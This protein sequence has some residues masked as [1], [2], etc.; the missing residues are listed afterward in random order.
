MTVDSAH[1]TAAETLAAIAE[2][3]LSAQAHARDCLD[4]IAERDPAVRAWAFLDPARVMAAAEA[5]DR[6][7][8]KGRLHGLAIG[9]K[10]VILTADMP[11][12]YNAPRHRGDNARIDAACVALLRDAGALMLGKTHTVEYAATG[13][14][15][16]TRNP[17]DHRRTPGGSSS[18]SAA[19]VADFHVSV[20]LGTQT[21]GSIIRPAAYCGVFGFKPT[22]GLVSREGAKAFAPT[23]DTVGWLARS[24]SDLTLIYDVFDTEGGDGPDL[25][26]RDMRI[27]VCRSPVWGQAQDATRR[28]LATGVR[29]LRRDGARIEDL[30]LPDS[31]AHLVGDHGLIMAAEGR[32]SFL[33]NYR[34]C[35]SRLHPSLRAMVENVAG[36]TGR[37]L[38]KAYD[39]AAA[40]RANFDRI[41]SGFDAILTPSVVGE[42]PIG[43]KATGPLTFNA[44][45]SLLHVPTINVPGLVGLKGLP[46]GLTVVGPRFADRQ[47]LAAARVIGD[48]FAR[49][50]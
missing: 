38:A 30:D 8:A 39:R 41:A 11:T 2:G 4:R 3:S 47:V 26:L 46:V 1:L 25:D 34:D 5:L 45:W 42:A 15:P 20:T 17:H 7:P 6:A 28:A 24:A 29:R 18:G 16:P 22:W 49:K 50:D 10:D 23:L 40:A 9:V 19:A 35:P 12:R 32:A 21:G 27:G 33:P 44:L 31:F 43:L 37:D 48:A 14:P 36:L 13:R